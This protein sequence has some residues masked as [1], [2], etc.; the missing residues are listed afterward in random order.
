MLVQTTDHR[1]VPKPHLKID[2][3]NEQKAPLLTHLNKH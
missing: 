2:G 1:T 3:A